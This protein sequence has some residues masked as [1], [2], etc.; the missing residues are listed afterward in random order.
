[1]LSLRKPRAESL[2][3]FLAAQAKL[4]FTYAA[5]GA[6]ADEPPLGYVVDRTRI[7]LGEGEAVFKAAKS[8]LERWEQFRLGWVEAWPPET[9]IRAGEVVAVIGRAMGLWWLNASRIVY[10]VNE[11]GPI[12]KFGFA[13]GTLPGHVETGEERFMIEWNQATSIVW[14]DILAFSRPN[15]I[16]TR[17][18]YP[19]VRRM[20]KRFGEDSAASMLRAIRPRDCAGT[21]G[22]CSEP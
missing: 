8:A 13:Y 15:H 1:M 9:P 12:S 5:V 18:G 21:A 10:V 11:S 22:R 16:L 3:R 20:Q 6:T 19:L 2:R 14:Y 17:L 4:D 7:K